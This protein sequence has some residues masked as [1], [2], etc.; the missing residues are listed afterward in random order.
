MN[1]QVGIKGEKLMSVFVDL[2]AAFD[3]VDRGVLIKTMKE[4][5]I[6]EELTVKVEKLAGE[7]RSRVRMGEVMGDSF[8]TARGIRQRCPL[9]LMLFNLLVAD[10]EE[11]MG[12]VR[13]GGVKL[14]KER[15]Y[16][17]SYAD[18]LVLLAEK[19]DEM[20]MLRRLKGYLKKKGLELNIS[21]TKV[22]KCRKEGDRMK[23]KV[24]RRKEKIV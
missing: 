13:W 19:E 23:K 9:S 15:V 7:R 20:R 24:L 8:W 14:Q 18:D 12:K 22:M 17:L 1:R 5:G 2:K 3:T 10:L 6:R 16:T 4:R 21:K 11:E